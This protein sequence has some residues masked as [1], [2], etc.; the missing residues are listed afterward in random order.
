MWT[1][2][3]S[4][5]GAA[6]GYGVARVTTDPCDGVCL[7]RFLALSAG[8]GLGL[9]V[10]QVI[11]LGVSTKPHDPLSDSEFRRDAAIWTAISIAVAGVGRSRELAGASLLLQSLGVSYAAH[12]FVRRED[13]L[14]AGYVGFGADAAGRPH[15]ILSLPLR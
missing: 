1:V 9:V 3:T 15:V 4:V 2:G 8:A 10:G 7:G 12:R 11:G 5:A 14:S 6:A 13:G